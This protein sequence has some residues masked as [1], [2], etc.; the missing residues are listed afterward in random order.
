MKS[1]PL[2]IV[3]LVV[4]VLFSCSNSVE[5]SEEFKKETTGKYLY[6]LEELIE[7][8]YEDNTLY[9]NW[10][11]GKIKPVATAENEFFVADMYA[12]L[13]FVT[14]PETKV[15][16]LSKL[17]D[18]KSDTITYDYIKM[19]DNYKTPSTFLKE[20]DYENALAG[21]LEIQKQ[22]ST[23]IYIREWDFNSKGY[24]HMRKREYDKAIRVLELN[25]ALHPNSAN[26]YDSLGEVY[27]RNGDSLQAYNNYKKTL[28]I[29][30]DNKRAKKYIDN[31]KLKTQ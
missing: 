3:L 12:K 2:L 5:Y 17:P 30:S 10:K 28:E 8:Y 19:P 6:N 23:S 14:H 7:V 15:R 16:Y 11:G 24:N 13:Y 27:L 21:Y 22:D 18:D 9:F 29:Y 26:V 25:A 4:A 20:G 31:Y 1:K